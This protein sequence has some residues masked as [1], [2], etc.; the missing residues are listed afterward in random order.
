MPADWMKINSEYVR[1]QAFAGIAGLMREGG[2]RSLA[3]IRGFCG[4]GFRCPGEREKQS[5]QLPENHYS[6]GPL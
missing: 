6:S 2:K 1:V 4:G 3:C 5:G